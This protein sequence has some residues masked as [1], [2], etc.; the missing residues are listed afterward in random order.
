MLK[1]NMLSIGLMAF[2]VALISFSSCK[3]DSGPSY[4]ESV[5]LI[6]S[7]SYPDTVS[8]SDELPI[9]FY[10]VIGNGCDFFSRF[11]DVE[12]DNSD[13]ANTLKIKIYRK[14][15]QD[16]A[17]TE[18]QKYLDNAVL[19]LTGMGSGDFFIKVVQPDNSYLEGKVFVKQ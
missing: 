6:D 15:E 14:T 18:E 12:L 7:I 11:E 16:V 2:F 4:V 10:G 17:C 1:K 19:K 13:S 8:I 9:Q 3:K 5:M